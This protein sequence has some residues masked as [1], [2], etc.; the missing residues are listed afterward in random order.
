MTDRKKKR[1]SMLDTLAAS[2]TPAPGSTMMS[3]NRALR[4]AR[5][6]VDSHRVWELE[7]EQIADTRFADRLDP[8]DVAD[9]RN[10]I[11]AN[12]QT[13]PILV[14]RHPETAD[15]YLL[16]YG[17][18]RLEAIRGSSE[19]TKVR[20][21]IAN[22]DETAALRAQI[23]ENTGRR[24][25]SFIERA[26]FAVELLD[27]GYG[28][29][30]QVAEVLNV[31]KSAVSMAVGV[32]RTVG[33]DL[34]AAIGPAHGIGRPKWDALARQ[35]TELNLDPAGLIPVAA[36]ARQRASA[37]AADSDTGPDPSTLAFEALARHLKKRATP[38]APAPVSS[39]PLQLSGA[40][41]GKLR[42]T[43]RGLQLELTAI[44]P[45]FAD[46]L[47][48]E[49]QGWITELHDRWKQRR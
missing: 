44:E 20:A 4:S 29:Q 6:A 30:T 27:S 36:E 39:V 17:R 38:T 7:P 21:L 19:V 33:P 9:L 23:S 37:E 3:S 47:E 32:A 24:D 34:A 25:L 11:E 46:W 48:E 49:A 5:D 22:L 18:R 14:R 40:R 13:V 28:N 43:A 16:V 12:G 42:R 41:V 10:S 45:D 1:M 15:R 8:Q 2:G 31:T 35:I 26:L